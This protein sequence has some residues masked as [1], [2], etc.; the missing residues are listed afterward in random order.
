MNHLTQNYSPN[1]TETKIKWNI[2]MRLLQERV[3]SV[4]KTGKF[5]SPTVELT[6][7]ETERRYDFFR[8]YLSNIPTLLVDELPYFLE[9]WN[10]YHFNGYKMKIR[11]QWHATWPVIL[12]VISNNF[13]NILVLLELFLIPFYFK[14]WPVLVKSSRLQSLT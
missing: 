14:M 9:L 3:S 7:R 10:Y 6:G 13:S 4:T 8:I 11:F 12:L 5:D 2:V 1:N